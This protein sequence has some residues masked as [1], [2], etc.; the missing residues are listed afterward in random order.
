[1]GFV[2]ATH[3]NDLCNRRSTTGLVYTFCGGVIFYES[4]TKFLSA[5]SSAETEFIAAHTAAKIS[6]YLRMILKQLGF[7]KTSPTPIHINNMSALKIIN[8]NK[9]ANRTRHNDIRYF[10]IQ[11]WRENGDIIM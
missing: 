9:S 6:Q 5:G 8:E 11:Y 7:E 3:V 10:A 2:D 4:K 1:M